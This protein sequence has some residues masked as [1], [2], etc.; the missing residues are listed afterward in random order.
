MSSLAA[1]PVPTPA[2]E[3]RARPEVHPWLLEGASAP[4]ILLLGAN[5]ANAFEA[6]GARVTV[7]GGAGRA[8]PVAA[9]L[10]APELPTW[11]FDAAFAEGALRASAGE[12]AA[13]VA[14][15]RR[16][17]RPAGRYAF[18]E[19][20]PS[21]VAPAALAV[22]RRELP[23][24]L[25]RVG[26]RPAALDLLLDASDAP[27]GRGAST[28]LCALDLVVLHMPALSRVAPGAIVFGRFPP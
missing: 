2:H 17:V 13:L 12:L 10:A 16:W 5:E 23:G 27:L 22:L 20:G 7:L 1:S 24:A 4:E 28:L 25:V 15:L 3:H 21:P 18:L 8:G 14:R 11:S 9:A 19:R 6:R 26:S